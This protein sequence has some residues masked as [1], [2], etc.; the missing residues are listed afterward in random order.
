MGT[1][2]RLYSYTFHLMVKPLAKKAGS[3]TKATAAPEDATA[4]SALVRP[5]LKMLAAHL[6]LSA[7]TVSFVLN[8]VP[9]RSIPDVT[10]ERVKAAAREF[11]YQPSL[12]ARK[13]QGQRVNT[14]GILLPELGDGYHSQLI[15]GAGDWLMREG[16]FYFTVHHK[17]KPELVSAYPEILEARGVEG[18]LAID[19]H[20]EKNVH[21]PTVLVAG[22]TEHRN[23]SNVI[24]DSHL[25]AELSLGHLYDLGHR[26]I[27]YMKGQAVSQDTEARWDA[28]MEVAHK[29]GLK[30]EESMIIRL[31]QDS[32]SPE[33]GYPGIK[34]MVMDGKRFTAVVCFNDVAAMGVIRALSDCGLRIPD[35]VSVIGYDDVQAAAYHVPS[36]TT[37]RQP[38]RKM[39][40]IAAM[41]LLDKLAGKATEHILQVEPELIV[42]ESTSAVHETCWTTRD[43]SIAVS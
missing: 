2:T 29:L 13:L 28:T 32:H 21:L 5:S 39:G 17:H 38:L 11:N 15:G 1:V 4:S 42:R 27:V 10:R 43:L 8:D 24:L 34:K 41:T 7:S 25:G 19:T 40:E 22:H 3:K 26:E 36:L 20:L 18:I 14:V 6:G 12:I 23:I 31:E 16:F 33:I 30:V 9:G 37:I 35:D